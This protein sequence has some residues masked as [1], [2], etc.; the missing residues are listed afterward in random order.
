MPNPISLTNGVARDL[1]AIAALQLE[2]KAELDGI[3]AFVGKGELKKAPE[4]K[5]KLAMAQSLRDLNVDLAPDKVAAGQLDE[6]FALAYKDALQQAESGID[7]IDAVRSRALANW[8][9]N[10]DV[11]ESIEERGIIPENIRAAGALDYVYVLGEK[12]GVFRITDA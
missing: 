10:V 6:Y 5:T 11:F 3:E 9:F 4:A 1:D 2:F 12:M 8:D 7:P